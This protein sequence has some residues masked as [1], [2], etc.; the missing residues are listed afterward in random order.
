MELEVQSGPNDKREKDTSGEKE[1]K[2]PFADADV[3]LWGI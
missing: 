3:Q 1:Y 2:G